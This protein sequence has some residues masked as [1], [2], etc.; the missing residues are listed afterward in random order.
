MKVM[1]IKCLTPTKSPL[2][3]FETCTQNNICLCLYAEK[4]VLLAKQQDLGANT[5]ATSQITTAITDTKLEVMLG[6]RLE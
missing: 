4:S 5:A 3:S 2:C 6:G 1:G